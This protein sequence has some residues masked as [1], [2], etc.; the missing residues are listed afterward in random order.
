LELLVC[1]IADLDFDA[2]ES[3]TRY[4]DGYTKDSTI[5]KQFCQTHTRRLTHLLRLLR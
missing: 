4:E 5:I 2:L 1:G 3:T